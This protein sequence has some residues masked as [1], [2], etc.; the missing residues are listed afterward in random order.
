MRVQSG[1]KSRFRDSGGEMTSDAELRVTRRPRGDPCWVLEAATG[2]FDRVGARADRALAQCFDDRRHGLRVMIVRAD[3]V[4]AGVDEY[5]DSDRRCR[6]GKGDA[7]TDLC[8]DLHDIH[9]T[10][11]VAT[12]RG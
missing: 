7:K 10:T 2:Q 11:I 6:N 4:N 5:R 9:S 3:V 12:M 8:R 1:A